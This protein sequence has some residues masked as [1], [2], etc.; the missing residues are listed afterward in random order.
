ARS[1]SGNFVLTEVQLVLRRGDVEQLLRIGGAVATYEQ[2]NLRVATAFDGDSQ[3][4]WAVY[5]GKPIDR[6]HAAVF[7]LAEAVQVM[8]GDQLMVRLRH[9]SPH[10]SHNLGRFRISTSA[11]AG[12]GLEMQRAAEVQQA[13]E[14]A[15]DKRS[16]SQLQ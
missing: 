3:T 9:D 16:E 10:I 15:A 1:D 13:L 5:A 7:R 6:E 2:G 4:G 11:V 8:P 14:T 12:A